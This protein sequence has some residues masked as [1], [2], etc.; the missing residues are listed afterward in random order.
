MRGVNGASNDVPF[1][2]S[3]VVMLAA[4][5]P[6]VPAKAICAEPEPSA[7]HVPTA[8]MLT[9]VFPLPGMTTLVV[10]HTAPVRL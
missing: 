9:A 8:L 2:P 6:G 3:M 7:A 4:S 5:P 10:P 1:T